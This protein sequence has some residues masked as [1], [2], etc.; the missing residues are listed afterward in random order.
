MLASSLL[1]FFYKIDG[2]TKV[3]M[4]EELAARRAAEHAEIS[5]E[6]ET[7]ES[8]ECTDCCKTCENVCDNKCNESC[9]EC[10]KTLDEITAENL[11]RELEEVSDDG[12]VTDDGNG[13]KE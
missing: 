4:R 13:E 7:T 9:D 8:A 3:Q 10:G 5:S 6:N 1:M 11:E 2:K 12:K